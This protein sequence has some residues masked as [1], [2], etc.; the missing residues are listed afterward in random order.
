MWGNNHKKLHL[1]C[2]VRVCAILSKYLS[3]VIRFNCFWLEVEWRKSFEGKRKA[4]IRVYDVIFT[5]VTFR[6][7]P[8]HLITL[9]SY[10]LKQPCSYFLPIVK[11]NPPLLATLFSQLQHFPCLPTSVSPSS[12]SLSAPQSPALASPSLPRPSAALGLAPCG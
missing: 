11:H 9:T 6:R 3:K 1:M 2:I 12:S 8:P 10:L 5:I 4:I 7:F